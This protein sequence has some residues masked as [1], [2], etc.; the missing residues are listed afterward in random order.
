MA[1]CIFC[2]NEADSKEDMFPRW[3]LKL[4]QTRYP[5]YRKIGDKPA[6]VTEDQEIRLPCVCMKCNNGWM[7]R[8]EKKVQKY[9]GLLI[10]DFS[11]PLDRDYQKGLAGWAVK[12][13][14]VNDTVE[15]HQRFFTEAECHA[16]KRD[17]TLPDGT[18]IV[19]G[20]FTDIS[21]DGVTLK[22]RRSVWNGRMQ[23][24]KTPSAVRE[25][26]LHPSI[27][28]VLKAHV[29]QATSGLLFSTTTGKP[30][31]QTN[32]LKR[33]LHPILKK[34]GCAKTGFHSF[35][36]YR[37]THL[38]KNRVPEDLLRYWLATQTRL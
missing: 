33:N 23:S 8:L 6:T 29:G 25:V 1:L 20:R 4:V 31:S 22:V 30:T 32:V 9:M 13:A 15:S 36:R 16:F 34:L 2:P 5:L 26:D 3:I 21:A 24:P 17:R 12:T 37:V 14:M 11:L 27:A 7:S 28:A 10:N 38:R 19:A 18:Q 35:R